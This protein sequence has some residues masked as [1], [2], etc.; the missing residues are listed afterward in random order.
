[1]CSTGSYILPCFIYFI[2]LKEKADFVSLFILYVV[3]INRT[4]HYIGSSSRSNG[5][6][7]ISENKPT[8]I[9][10]ISLTRP[11]CNT[12]QNLIL[13]YQMLEL[14]I[15]STRGFIVVYYMQYVN[16]QFACTL[17]PKPFMITSPLCWQQLQVVWVCIKTRILLA[18]CVWLFSC[19]Y[20]YLGTTWS[21]HCYKT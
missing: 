18:V 7:R 4:Q 6:S 12:M 17:P 21:A 2:K 19:K 5:I 8:H 16:I 3:D 11:N 1:M 14:V 20:K 9:Q 15:K 10:H 13:Q